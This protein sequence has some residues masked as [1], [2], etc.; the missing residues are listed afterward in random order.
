MIKRILENI[1]KGTWSAA[2]KLWFIVEKNMNI[3]YHLYK[4]ASASNSKYVE[5]FP[6]NDKAVQV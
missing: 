6:A 5:L 1:S 3:V 4:D 2:Q